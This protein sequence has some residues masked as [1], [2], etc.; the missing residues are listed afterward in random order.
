MLFKQ[1]LQGI[2]YLHSVDIA[3]RDIKPQNL[4]VTKSEKVY[5]M[6]FNVSKKKDESVDTFRM[7]TK[8]GTVAFSAPEIFTHQFYDTKVDVWSAGIVL[9]MMLSGDQPFYSDNH[10][11][12]VHLITTAAPN[13]EK[14]QIK[15]VSEE[16][17][18]L[19]IKMLNK[20][21][22]ERPNASECL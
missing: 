16:A 4:L 13:M 11:K 2:E 22:D 5:I 15:A 14:E 21:P 17:R 3:H 6:D 1:I 9:Y 20:N 8:T 18:D 12:V 10:A 19:L 7:M